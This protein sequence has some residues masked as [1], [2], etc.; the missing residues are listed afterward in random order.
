MFEDMYLHSIISNLGI[1]I[2]QE[3]NSEIIVKTNIFI[4]KKMKFIHYLMSIVYFIKIM[5]LL[6]QI[7]KILILLINVNF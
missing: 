3:N 2:I 1:A 4:M 6:F 5:E 7:F